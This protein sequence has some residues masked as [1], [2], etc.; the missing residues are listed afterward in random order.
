MDAQPIAT[1]QRAAFGLVL[2]LFNVPSS[3]SVLIGDALPDASY[4]GPD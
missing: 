2:L 4:G 1:D 3:S